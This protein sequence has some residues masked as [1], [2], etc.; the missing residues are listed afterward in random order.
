MG[1]PQ[2]SHLHS[3]GGEEGEE[4]ERRSH[5]KA[6][7]EEEPGLGAEGHPG[8]G[9]RRARTSGQRDFKGTEAGKRLG[10]LLSRMT[11]QLKM[12]ELVLTE[13][14]KVPKTNSGKT[15]SSQDLNQNCIFITQHKSG[16]EVVSGELAPGRPS[17]QKVTAR[18]TAPALSAPASNRSGVSGAKVKSVQN[19]NGRIGARISSR[20]SS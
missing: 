8:G 4:M 6:E 12:V 13:E 18:T 9:A 5:L 3:Q 19:F 7:A 20:N 11:F 2:L 14:R 17:E 15:L 1:V 16:R 10:T